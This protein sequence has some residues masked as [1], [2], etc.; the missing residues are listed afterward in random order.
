MKKRKKRAKQDIQALFDFDALDQQGYFVAPQALDQQWVQRLRRAFEDSDEQSSGTQH[1]EIV[2][3]TP[4]LDAWRALETHPL[5]I[6]AAEHVL[7][8]MY[9][10]SQLHGRNPLAGSGQQSLHPDWMPRASGDSYFVLT[11][12]WMLDDFTVNNGTRVVPESHRLA[13]GPPKSFAQPFFKYPDEKIIEGNA[14][15]VLIF[16]GHLWHSG[17]RNDSNGPR[18]AVQLVLHK[19]IA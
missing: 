9:H 10:V 1:V 8:Q 14:G 17:R 2:E 15:D 4:E 18:R 7:G 3:T 13:N 5:L 11:S 16:N 19:G 6:A 12:L